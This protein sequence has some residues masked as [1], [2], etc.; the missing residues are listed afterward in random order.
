MRKFIKTRITHVEIEGGLK[1]PQY[2]DVEGTDWYTTRDKDGWGSVVMTDLSGLV[3]AAEENPE[4]LSI[5]PDTNIYEVDWKTVPEDPL[6]RFTFVEG[7]F[8]P[9]V[10]P[11]L[12]PVR[13]KEDIM[14]DL[15]K[16]QEELKAL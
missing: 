15:L 4:F 12:A 5:C 13:T 10:V 3:I 8:V 11:E 14:S 2:A 1:F 6:G 7:Q 16:L 9:V